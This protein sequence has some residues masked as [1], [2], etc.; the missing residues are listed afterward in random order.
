MGIVSFA[1]LKLAFLA[2]AIAVFFG[3]KPP[4][5]P[6]AA[7]PFSVLLLVGLASVVVAPIAEEML[8]RGF[9]FR[10]WAASRLGVAGTI[11]LTSLLFAALHWYSAMGV[12]FCFC[13]GLLSG[14]LRWRLGSLTAPILIHMLNNGLTMGV[15]T[16]Q[17]VLEPQ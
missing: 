5:R 8:F 10:G 4:M 9:L 3:E 14:W 1:T 16:V 17:A 2:I 11:A 7:Q 12:A 6:H 15:I 13:A